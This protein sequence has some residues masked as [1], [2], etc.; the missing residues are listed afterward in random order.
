MAFNGAQEAFQAVQHSAENAGDLV[1]Q[2]FVYL[3]GGL[4]FILGASA[5]SRAG[6][7]AAKATGKAA[8]K[9]TG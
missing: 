6:T 5:V 1:V 4:A 2:G 3:F 8:K 9:I 7:E